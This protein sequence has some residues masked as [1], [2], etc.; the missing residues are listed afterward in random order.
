MTSMLLGVGN[1]LQSTH[2]K[3]FG[4]FNDGS[5]AKN[6][7]Q[8]LLD[9]TEHY[10][11]FILK[12]NFLHRNQ[13]D[14][15]TQNL[16]TSK[17]NVNEHENLKNLSNGVSKRRLIKTGGERLKE[18]DSANEDEDNQVVLTRLNG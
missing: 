17:N 11:R 16:I 1:A 9:K 10:T 12:Q 14:K 6:R 2:K 5:T 4:K 15:L 18:D 13:K 7:L 8:E 3:K